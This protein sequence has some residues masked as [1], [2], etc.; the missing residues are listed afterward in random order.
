MTQQ[1]NPTLTARVAALP[2][3]SAFVNA[4]EALLRSDPSVFWVP[5]RNV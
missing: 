2:R 3:L 1:F 5:L 4:V